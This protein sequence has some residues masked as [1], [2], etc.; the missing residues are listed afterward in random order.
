MNHLMKNKLSI[1]LA[2]TCFFYITQSYANEEILS[3]KQCAKIES[4]LKRLSCF[5]K[6]V[7][8]LN[9]DVAIKQTVAKRVV[10]TESKIQT[11]KPESKS[12]T[13]GLEKKIAKDN[14]DEIRSR[15]EG[16]FNGWSG[17]TIFKLQNG[18]VWK[19][20][21]SG[22]KSHSAMNPEVIIRKGAFGSYRLKVE[23]IN[24]R[25]YVKRIK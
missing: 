19:Q 6:V 24:A 17:K 11:V 5:D 12:S 3:I 25:I 4:D 10:N 16:E 14:P 23:G 13:F 21:G 18:Q 9:G 2:L 20:S 1:I 15:I 7:K 8:T 22:H